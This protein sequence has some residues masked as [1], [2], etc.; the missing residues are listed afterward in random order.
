MIHRESNQLIL[1][2]YAIDAEG[3]VRVIECIARARH[4]CHAAPDRPGK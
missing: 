4:G 2:P 1:G 3:R